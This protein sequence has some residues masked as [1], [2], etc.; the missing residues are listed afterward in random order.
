M[1]Y[2]IY[3]PATVLVLSEKKKI[4]TLASLNGTSGDDIHHIHLHVQP[5]TN[6]K[7]P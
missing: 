2:A 7:L 6:N 5:I 4:Q 3:S 1:T